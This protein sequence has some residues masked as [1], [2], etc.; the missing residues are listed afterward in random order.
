MSLTDIFEVGSINRH[1]C[2]D[3]SSAQADPYIAVRHG[4]VTSPVTDTSLAVRVTS[5]ATAEQHGRVSHA[6][7]DG[8]RKSISRNCHFISFHHVTQKITI[9]Q[10]GRGR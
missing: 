10:Q 1:F 4:D 6:S 5:P 9:T 7:S 2:P 8:N 3:R